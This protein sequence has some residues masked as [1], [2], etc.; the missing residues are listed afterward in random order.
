MNEK[1]DQWLMQTPLGRLAA[2]A[3]AFWE[4]PP[5]PDPWT[6]EEDE[7]ARSDE[8]L[9][10]CP[11]C[12]TPQEGTDWFCPKCGKAVG[13]YNN[14]MPFVNIFSVGEVARAGVGNEVPHN[15]L[16]RVGYA[17]FAVA[18]YAFAFPIYLFRLVFRWRKPEQ[19]SGEQTRHEPPR[20]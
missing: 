17:L 9:P 1:F 11:H 18:A 10:L 12:L 16:T 13:P 15:W 3:K 19:E 5:P 14:M 20:G 8:A 7:A 4:A 6:G 2:R